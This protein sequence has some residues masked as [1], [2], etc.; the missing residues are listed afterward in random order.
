MSRKLIKAFILTFSIVLVTK[1]PPYAIAATPS[2][3]NIPGAA[4]AHPDQQQYTIKTS[5]LPAP[6]TALGTPTPADQTALHQAIAAYQAAKAPIQTMPLE[7]F[8][9]QHPN[10]PWT[11]SLWLNIGLIHEQAAD[12]PAAIRAF[13]LALA[14]AGPETQNNDGPAT[15][16]LAELL[17]LQ[18]AYGHADQIKA[19]L[20]NPRAKTHNALLAAPIKSATHALWVMQHEPQKANRS[21]TASLGE[22]IDVLNPHSQKLAGIKQAQT[23]PQGE[24]LAALQKLAAEAGTPLQVVRITATSPIPFPSVMHWTIGHYTTIIGMKNGLYRVYDPAF[25]QEKLISR[26]VLPRDKQDESAASIRVRIGGCRAVAGRR[27]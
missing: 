15:R 27:A 3:T 19:L 14:A 9:V 16:A 2:G 17:T 22:L 20:A 5:A 1:A 8:A 13:N 7:L 18:T 11:A 21:G 23:S 10:S 12:Y 4:P 6:L 24:S 25:E 26:E